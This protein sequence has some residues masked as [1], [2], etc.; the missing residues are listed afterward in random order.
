[1]FPGELSLP[2]LLPESTK[3]DIGMFL[4]FGN[5][6]KVDY[7]KSIDDS[8]KIRSTAGL[9]ASWTSPVGPMT[10]VLSQNISKASTDVTETF[11]FK[12]GTTF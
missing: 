4:D 5:L 10:F 8:N 2:D 3:T 1:M 12:L 7:A 11:N 6:W 9:N